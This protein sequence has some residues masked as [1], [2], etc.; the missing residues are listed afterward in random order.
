MPQA[1]HLF[2]SDYEKAIH[3]GRIGDN[4]RTNKPATPGVLLVGAGG[5]AHDEWGAGSGHVTY[6][7]V[8]ATKPPSVY[9]QVTLDEDYNRLYIDVGTSNDQAS[10]VHVR[11]GQSGQVRGCHCHHQH[12]HCHHRATTTSRP[13]TR[14]PA[15]PGGRG[16][17]GAM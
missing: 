8:T 12:Q 17:A 16:G 13:P 7:E 1:W 3:K 10:H 15:A 4:Q 14:R 6:Y 9:W 2:T 11:Y 5:Y